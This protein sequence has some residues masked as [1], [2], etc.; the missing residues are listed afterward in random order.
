MGRPHPMIH[1]DAGLRGPVEPHPASQEE[2]PTMSA[3]R[4][5]LASATFALLAALL[6]L[7]G[8][9]AGELQTCLLGEDDCVNVDAPDEVADAVGA[10]TDGA[11]KVVE[12]VKDGT[13]EATGGWTE[14]VDPV[15]DGITQTL[16]LTPDEEGG[17]GKNKK[18]R[19]KHA[20]RSAGP[21]SSFNERVAAIANYERAIAAL[22]AREVAQ[23]IDNELNQAASF[24]PPEFPTLGER[25]AQAAL[26]AAKAFTFPALLIGLVVGFVLMQNRIDHKDP[27]L[28]FAPVSSDQEY[29]S[30]T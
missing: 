8:A 5:A 6:P 11:T 7:S 19:G 29:L 12:G 28:A 30:F 14:P 21:S 23:V 16:D 26:D 3:G 9:F 20:E 27:K 15:V 13:D 4:K 22:A 18:Q 2:T 1:V 17:K 24:V 25:L 10:T